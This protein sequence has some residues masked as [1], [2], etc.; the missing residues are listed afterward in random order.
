MPDKG[1]HKAV[2]RLREATLGTLWR[3]WGAL[4]AITARGKSARSLVDPEALVLMSLSLTEEE[5]RLWDLLYWWARVGATLLSVQRIKNLASMYPES[6]RARLGGFAYLASREGR[7]FRWRPLERPLSDKPIRVGKNLGR[8]PQL[9]N[10]TALLVRLRVGLGVSVKVD[11]LCFLLA[12]GDLRANVR[13]IAD[14]VG[15]TPRAVHRAVDDMV[16]ARVIQTTGEMPTAYRVDPKPWTELLG[17]SGNVPVWRYWTRMF[18]FV[19]DLAEW[20]ERENTAMQ[21]SPYLRSSQ[22]R[23]LMERHRFAFTRNQLI[24]PNPDDYPGEQ[25]LGAFEETLDKVALWLEQN[26]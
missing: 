18:A 3:Q 8:N 21:A 19:A 5:R 6:T 1:L 9:I 11:V 4:G 15:Y 2:R 14:A 7:D 20:E 23:D 17:V 26:V 25:Y 13:T 16:T 12:T 22:V 24:I 10:P